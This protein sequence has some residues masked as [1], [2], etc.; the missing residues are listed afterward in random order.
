[1]PFSAVETLT[2]THIELVPGTDRIDITLDDRLGGGVLPGERVDDEGNA[3]GFVAES[4]DFRVSDRGPANL[5][6]SSHVRNLNTQLVY[7]SA[8]GLDN[9]RQLQP[10][11]VG[12]NV[13]SLDGWVGSIGDANTRLRELSGVSAS[14]IRGVTWRRQNQENGNLI[15]LAAG[16]RCLLY[17]SPSPRDRG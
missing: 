8:G 3:T 1:M 2:G 9:I 11:F 16:A 17:T 5:T 13:Q 12:L 14:R 15:A 4:L 10:G 6:F 7:E